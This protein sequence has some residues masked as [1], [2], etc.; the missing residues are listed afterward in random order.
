MNINCNLKS[1]ELA[2]R[3]VMRE[4]KP[5]VFEKISNYTEKVS[6]GESIAILRLEYDYSCNFKCQH[7]CN[8]NFM[9]NTLEKNEK[10]SSE[11]V[12][13]FED[14]KSISM[15]GDEMGL[16][17]M[18]ITGGEPL[19]YKD[20]DKMIE[21]IDP[22]KWYIACDTNGWFLDHKKANHIK[23]IGVD[24]IQI[25]LD[26]LDEK[27]HDRFRQKPGSFKRVMIAID[28]AKS[29]G[30]DIN[31]STVAWKSRVHS[32]EFEAFISWAD[33]NGLP[34]YISLAKPVGAFARRFDEVCNSNDIKHIDDLCRKYS[35]FTHW[36]PS[37]G[38]DIGCIAVK[39]MITVT[40]YGDVTPCPYT[41]ISLGSIYEEP[42]KDIVN[43]GLKIKMFSYG[44]K[45]TCFI[46]DIDH[47]FIADKLPRYQ[48]EYAGVHAA[49]YRVVF[50]DE[51]F[52]D[53]KIV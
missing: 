25:S 32:D 46:G 48:D 21:A 19:V 20:F 6:K 27:Q 2:R 18:V 45:E 13:T 34:L 36:T 8:D 15:Q 5:R 1:N 3:A 38:L 41:H 9:L 22:S 30:L 50:D 47:P 43:R 28:A 52:I 17:N 39:R 51:D 42:L 29:V 24:K 12:L 49:P 33:K 7:C 10:Y 40:K 26:G 53:G 4:K 11:R 35:S 23:S 14:V 37:Y 16:A 44:V 31:L